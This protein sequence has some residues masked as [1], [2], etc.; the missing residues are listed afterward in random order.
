MKRNWIGVV[1]SLALVGILSGCGSD[2]GDSLGIGNG[3]PAVEQM[4]DVALE[5][6]LMTAEMLGAEI[7]LMGVTAG[8]TADDGG[9]SGGVIQGRPVDAHVL[10]AQAE[11]VPQRAG[12]GQHRPVAE[13]D[14]LLRT[15]RPRRVLDGRDVVGGGMDRVGHRRARNRVLRPHDRGVAQLGVLLPKQRLPA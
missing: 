3:D 9:P 13:Q 4:A 11:P 8:A 6:D 15:R 1:V 12:V 7:D 10:R 5:S 2:P 14:P